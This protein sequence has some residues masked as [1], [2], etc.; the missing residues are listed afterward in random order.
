M[1]LRQMEYLLAAVEERSFT[2]AARRLEVAQP[3]L[4]HQVRALEATVGETLVE[5]SAGAVHLTPAGRAYLPHAAAALRAADEARRALH[6][7]AGPERF[8][9]R[10]ATLYSLALGILPPAIRAWRTA[11][12]RARVELREYANA[13]EL[14][15]QTALGVADVGVGPR[16][17]RWSGP[18]TVLGEEE[19]VVVLPSD[20]PLARRRR[21]RLAAL[22]DRSWV[23]YAT[24]NSLAPVVERA[25]AD[26]G[27]IPRAAVRT[28]HTATAVALAAAGL[29]PALAPRSIIEPSLQAALIRPDPPVRRELVAYTTPGR[30]EPAASFIAL[31]ADRGAV[32]RRRA[33]ASR[34]R[35][36]GR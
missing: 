4:S 36:A 31:L 34:A 18:L 35:P 14:A 29:G 33:T 13:E 7:D 15:A 5:R 8:G 30:A 16:P 25:C 21:L 9:L 24:D 6:G 12:P 28:R 17:R 3:T 22:A 11:H 10:I 23:L 19:L 32:R 27:F 26:A 2:A 20:D 1:S